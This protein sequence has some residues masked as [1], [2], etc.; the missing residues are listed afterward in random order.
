M[1]ETKK[2]MEFAACSIEIFHFVKL[3]SQHD[4]IPSLVQQVIF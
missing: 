4:R 1:E 2:K 3:F